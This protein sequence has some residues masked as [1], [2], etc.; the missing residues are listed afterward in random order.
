PTARVRLPGLL[1]LGATGFADPERARH[2]LRLILEG[3]P[4]VPY[5]VALREAL[6]RMLPA[7]LDALWKSGDPDEALNPFERFLAAAGPRTG[8]IELLAADP[9]VLNGVVKLCAG[10]DLL[11]QLLIAQP[12]LLT[13]LADREAL[14]R[15]RA[16]YQ[17][18]PLLAPV[19][20][21]G[22]PAAERR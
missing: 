9:G 15:P 3:R 14:A 13:S 19:F 16:R 17:F 20:A 8:L 11:T 18:R 6:A 2:N 5:A 22:V 1:A 12:E 4:L 10:G 21:P 7:L